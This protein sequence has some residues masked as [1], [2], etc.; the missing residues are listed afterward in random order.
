MAQ[1]TPGCLSPALLL[2]PPQYQFPE[3]ALAWR[4]AWAWAGGKALP[5]QPKENLK[6]S[7]KNEINPSVGTLTHLCAVLDGGRTQPV[8]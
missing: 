5:T 6:N 7:N 1:G 4:G 3:V 2:L 8:G